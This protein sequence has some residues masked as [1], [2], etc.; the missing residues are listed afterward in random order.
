M[1]ANCAPEPWSVREGMIHCT[2]RHTGALRTT[3]QYENFILE[4][5]WRH[6]SRGGNSG[7]FI[8]GTPIAAPAVPFL[9]GIEV[10]VLDH[11]LYSV[12]AKGSEI[13]VKRGK[14]ESQRVH[15]PAGAKARGPFGLRDNGA[16][17][18]LMNLYA[19]EL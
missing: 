19:R 15:L 9:R 17:K 8:C 4:V 11:D 10:Q 6:L 7:V 14:K 2:G 12:T 5:E 16:A 1:N 3:R 13:V 18:E